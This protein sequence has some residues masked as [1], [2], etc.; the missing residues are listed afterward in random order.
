MGR[1]P[2]L[3][4]S[5]MKKLFLTTALALLPVGAFAADL[6]KRA[7]APAPAPMMVAAHNWTG[8]YAG[9]HAGYGWG[10]A[11]FGITPGG[12]W[13]GDPDLA[14]VTSAASGSPR[15]SGA[16]GGIQAGYNY[17]MNNVVLGVEVDV[18]ASGVNGRFATGS[19]NGAAAG[20][21]DVYSARGEAGADW[22]AT[23]RLRFGI[24]ADKALFYVTGG[25]IITENNFSH[26]INFVNTTGFVALPVTSSSG[27]ANAGSNSRVNFGW[28]VGAGVEY[29]LSQ[30]WSAKLEYL[31]ADLG[32]NAVSSRYAQTS[33][34][35]ANF[36]IRH[37]ED[38]TL[39]IVRVGLN[40]KFGGSAAPVVARY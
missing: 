12:S 25:A 18:S 22:F 14:G 35:V 8:F 2:R 10:E 31:Y 5:K 38:K 13:V 21:A 32:S 29:A 30:N 28:V 27:G 20:T 19:F 11:D 4:G 3:R 1:V 23:A 36:D 17:Q 39:S 33:P 9:V 40:Y 34:S 7:G 15:I 37:R 24:A 26:S 6:P 16:L